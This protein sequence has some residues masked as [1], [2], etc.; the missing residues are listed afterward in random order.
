[1]NGFSERL[2]TAVFFVGTML[3]GI[4]ISKW[5]FY[6]LFLIIAG[7]C[8]W[9]LLKL[10]FK[11]GK[12]KVINS[13]RLWIGIAFG[14][15]LYLY[16]Y[17]N[18]FPVF[19]SLGIDIFL[20]LLFLIALFFLLLFVEMIDDSTQAPFHNVSFAALGFIYIGMPFFLIFFISDAYRPFTPNIVFGIVSMT[21]V[22]DTGAYL[23]GSWIGRTPFLPRISPN[24]TVE[25]VLGG[26]IATIGIS[27]LEAYVFDDLLP[28]EWL[29]LAAI[30]AILGPAGDLVESTMKRHF[31]IKDTSNLLPGH[32][33]FLDRFDSLIF[34]L[35]YAALYLYLRKEG[36]L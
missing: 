10:T 34:I 12:H 26:T 6:T 5:T 21:W 20:Y 24:K 22:N 11:Q 35:P 17:Y 30:V 33:G 16:Y 14:L 19:G 31:K 7:F 8:L 3:A 28:C 1:M 23:F 4:F 15:S 27:F 2:I 25:G 18:R 13:I 36:F 29:R 32:G 9:E